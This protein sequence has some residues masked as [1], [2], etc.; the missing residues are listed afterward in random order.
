MMQCKVEM[1]SNLILNAVSGLQFYDNPDVYIRELL[2]NA[3]D[4]CNTR[5]ALEYSWYDEFHASPISAE[6]FDCV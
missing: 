4:A 6:D 3:I 1:K 5:A 2:V